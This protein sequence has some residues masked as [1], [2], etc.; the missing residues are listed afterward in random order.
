MTY[1]TSTCARR[2]RPVRIHRIATYGDGDA[3]EVQLGSSA[4]DA[5]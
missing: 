4:E 2:N 3:G 5:P 1:L